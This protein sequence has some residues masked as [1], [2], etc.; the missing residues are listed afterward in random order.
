MLFKVESA[1]FERFPDAR[2]GVI[3]ASALNN[4]GASLDILNQ[5]REAESEIRRS[6][7]DKTVTEHPRI[8]IWR[9]AYRKFG[10]KPKKYPSSIENLV[11][12]VLK[13]EDL[14]PISKLVD[15]YNTVSL[16]HLLPVGGEDLAQIVGDIQ[17]TIA[18]NDEPSVKLLGEADPRAPKPGEVIYKD[19]LGAI[20]R[21]WNWKEAD[22]TKITE[23]TT[24]A[25]L[26]IESLP[27]VSLQEL[28]N[29]ISDLTS[30]LE[31]H[32]GAHVESEILTETHAEMDL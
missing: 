20:C 4:S 1:I 9:E 6:V 30:R 25:V 16:R 23:R 19:A 15:I 21:R 24:R 2:I 26:V 18:G 5:L 22:R 17:L 14:R 3:T 10:A 32:C 13:G 12:R 28:E 31:Q 29:A 11:R 7:Q 8:S 27:P